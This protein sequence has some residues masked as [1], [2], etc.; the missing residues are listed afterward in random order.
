MWFPLWIQT[1]QGTCLWV[2]HVESRPPT[3]MITGSRM[4][5]ETVTMMLMNI[6]MNGLNTAV[7][8]HSYVN[9]TGTTY[10]VFTKLYTLL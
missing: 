4:T 5:G 7:D 1:D 6:K 8:G 3:N 10:N 9:D 2:V